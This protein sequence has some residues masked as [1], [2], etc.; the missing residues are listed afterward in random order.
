M[1]KMGRVPIFMKFGVPLIFLIFGFFNPF[2]IPFLTL[3]GSK[4]RKIDL[5]FELAM[6]KIGCVPIFMQFEEPLIFSGFDLFL[7][8]IGYSGVERV[9]IYLLLYVALNL[10]S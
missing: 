7:G 2:L 10:A 5:I 1:V 9:K 8:P 6:V 4:F 3:K